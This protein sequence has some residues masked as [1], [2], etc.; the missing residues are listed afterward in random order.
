MATYLSEEDVNNLILTHTA[1]QS[2]PQEPK[3]R[4]KVIRR[5]QQ[6][7]QQQQQR[8][9]EGTVEWTE[10]ALPNIKQEQEQ[11]REQQPGK[12]EWTENALTKMKQKQQQEQEQQQQ[13]Q[14]G[15]HHGK[16]SVLR[17][18]PSEFYTIDPDTLLSRL[19][20]RRLFQRWKEP[21]PVDDPDGEPYI[22]PTDMT[23]D[24][25]ANLE[26]ENILLRANLENDRDRDD[27]GTTTTPTPLPPRIPCSKEVLMFS[28]CPRHVSILASYPRSGNSLMR[29]MYE[30]I[31]LRVSGS[32]MRG[33]LVEHDLV[34]EAA[35][36]EN[37]VQFVKTHFPE[38]LGTPV[39]P[40]SRVVLLVR[41]PYDA[42]ESYFNLMMTGTH[43]T[44]L[45]DEMR[46]KTNEIWESMVRKE[47]QVWKEFHE[48]WLKQDVP[49]LLV[50][51][52]DLI[53]FP[54]ETM[55]RVIKFTLDVRTHTHSVPQLVVFSQNSI[56]VCVFL[57]SPPFSFWIHSQQ[58][59]NMYFFGRRVRY[60]MDQ[61][62]N[63]AKLGSYQPRSGGI[64]KSLQKYSPELLQEMNVGLLS[65][66]EKFEYT[67]LLVPN[68][69]DW[70]LEPLEGH[71]REYVPSKA[72]NV[73]MVNAGPLVRTPKHR[74]D[75]AK[76]KRQLAGGVQNQKCQ[77]A[78]CRGLGK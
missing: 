5:R 21:I 62:Q 45:T 7:R 30:R 43:T 57:F 13:Q 35:T 48:Y 75:W 59:N 42:L 27:K 78:K 23:T 8:E 29:T 63:I 53:R 15:H 49:I 46:A 22:Y 1:P 10:S 68:K 25:I 3:G 65:T 17:N 36:G 70:E 47:V 54:Y 33:G 76:I 60:C 38:R 28:P 41:N 16:N 51:Y 31:T 12:V 66:M 19:N 67:S 56:D 34:G 72:N 73:V 24:E 18:L 74:T 20:T 69:E 2:Q 61:E 55:C 37:R 58:V 6:K 52:E 71:A 77:C 50:R 64:G 11:K 44:S 40:A 4:Q 14:Q 26:W 39:F 9:Q 32:D